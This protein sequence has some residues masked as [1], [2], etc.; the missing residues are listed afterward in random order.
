MEKINGKQQL[1]TLSEGA[2]YNPYKALASAI[3]RTAIYDYL[4]V[5]RLQRQGK[6]TMK[7][8]LHEREVFY[9]DWFKLLFS[10][11][12]LDAEDEDID[13]YIQCIEG[14]K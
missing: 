13:Y 1:K 12:G 5:V 6:A 7:R 3:I 11:L 8:V 10:S 2:S 4:D 9:S 14:K